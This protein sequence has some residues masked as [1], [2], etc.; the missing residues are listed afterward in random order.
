MPQDEVSSAKTEDQHD[1]IRVM[2]VDDSAVIRG[3]ISR[4]LE[5]QDD[6]EVC[7]SVHNGAMAVRSVARH[8]PDVMVLDIEMPE[9]DGLTALPLILKENSRTKVLMCSTLSAKG[10]DVSI[11]ALQLGA[12]DCIVKPTTSSEVGGAGAFKDNL[13]RLVRA[14]GKTSMAD[15][16]RKIIGSKAPNV[17]VQPPRPSM[18][19][20][21]SLRSPVG[22]YTGSASLI[23][24]GSSTGGPQALFKVI[25]HLQGAK[26]PIVITQHMPKTFTA[27]L[28]KHIEQNCGVP[29][30]EGEDGMVLRSG[31]AYVAPGGFHMV[32]EREGTEVK[33]RVIDTEAENYC[34]PSVEPMMRSAISLYGEKILAV[35]LTGM[36]ND[37]VNSFTQL[38]EM[39]GRIVAQDEETSVVW[40]MPGA[41]AA[42]GICK[43]ILPI[44]EIGP[45]VQKNA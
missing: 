8:D 15:P 26:V 1:R 29:C 34:K 38:S 30:F 16:N 42:A 41:V 32:F 27:L 36:G 33:I 19:A 24:I 35:M 14:L 31:H 6:I 13:I 3:L 11:K 9:M 43:E 21:A 4:S 2:L 40:G 7:A 37:G 45:W 12:T 17:T 5:E 22:L 44:D 18:P 10:A 20:K 25:K 39:G 28:A 23:A